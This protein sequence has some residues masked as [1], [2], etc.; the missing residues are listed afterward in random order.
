LFTQITLVP[1]EN[2]V[3]DAADRGGGLFNESFIL[4]NAFK[5]IL[6][7]CIRFVIGVGEGKGAVRC[8]NCT[9]KFSPA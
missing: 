9:F 6:F 7:A 5:R 4:Q 8:E 1:N 3:F 2:Y